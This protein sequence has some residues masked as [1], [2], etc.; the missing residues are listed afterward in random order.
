MTTFLPTRRILT[1]N[2]NHAL[3]VAMVNDLTFDIFYLVTIVCLNHR[4]AL[5]RFRFYFAPHSPSIPGP[6][7]EIGN[8][9]DHHLFSPGLDNV[10]HPFPT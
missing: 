6:G 4:L 1:S 7:L 2:G 10:T 8:Q 9:P 5:M 3:A